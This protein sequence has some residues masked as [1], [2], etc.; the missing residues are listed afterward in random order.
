M[1]KVTYLAQFENGES[2]SRTSLRPY[3]HA[4]M[5]FDDGG[6][7]ASGFATSLSKAETAANQAKC[8]YP[9]KNG[10]R[11]EVVATTTQS[12]EKTKADKA[13]LPYRIGYYFGKDD[14]R[15]G[16]LEAGTNRHVRKA[17]VDDALT[18]AEYYA[19]T[20]RRRQFYIFKG[21]GRALQEVAA[22]LVRRPQLKS[23]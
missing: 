6:R 19:Y 12:I 14:S 4:W 18:L 16:W 11:A 1:T 15:I 10:V 8:W 23:A 9:K 3:T 20:D 2:L 13:A 5:V 22:V 21:T 7:L 17:T